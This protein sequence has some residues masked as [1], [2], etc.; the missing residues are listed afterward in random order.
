MS[1]FD[2]QAVIFESVHSTRA[3][4]HSLLLQII[5]GCMF[6][7]LDIGSRVSLSV[8][9]F[10]LFSNS[11]AA[12]LASAGLLVHGN[13]SNSSW[14]H[15]LGLFSSHFICVTLHSLFW[16]TLL[17]LTLSQLLLLFLILGSGQ[18]SLV[19]SSHWRTCREARNYFMIPNFLQQIGARDYQRPTTNLTFVP[20][21]F[22]FL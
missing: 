7:R 10:F 9:Y 1:T 11:A 20:S 6:R 14:I 2:K 21:L 16:I 17:L 22:C 5:V 18:V 12:F 13:K 4:E 3:T 8:S 15:T 19:S